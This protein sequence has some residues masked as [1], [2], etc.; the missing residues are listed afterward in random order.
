MKINGK[1]PNYICK[2][3]NKMDVIQ[4]LNRVNIELI[5][6]KCGFKSELYETNNK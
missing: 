2:C 6:N 1:H 4:P 3:G 5:C